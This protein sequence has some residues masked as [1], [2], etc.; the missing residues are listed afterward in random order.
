MKTDKKF[1]FGYIGILGLALSLTFLGQTAATPTGKPA[2]TMTET[3]SHNLDYS[4]TKLDDAVKTAQLLQLQLQKAQEDVQEKQ[5][6]FLQTWDAICKA[7]SLEPSKYW[8][9][10]NKNIYL[11]PGQTESENPT[12]ATK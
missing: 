8:S 11:R 9:S 6:A 4:S 1:V 2:A 7:H 10:D 12:K 3:E 5:K